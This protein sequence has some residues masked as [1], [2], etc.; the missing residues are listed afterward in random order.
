MYSSAFA[1][2]DSWLLGSERG[3][4]VPAWIVSAY[5]GLEETEGI[6][7]ETLEG[8]MGE[9]E[10]WWLEVTLSAP[11]EETCSVLNCQTARK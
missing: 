9:S 4:R 5:V 1:T 7:M 2:G 3:D 8:G 11:C 10:W 6:S